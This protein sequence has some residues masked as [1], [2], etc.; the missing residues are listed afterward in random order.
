LQAYKRSCEFAREKTTETKNEM[1]ENFPTYAIFKKMLS[2]STPDLQTY[3][4]GGSMQQFK[5]GT[6]AQA[7]LLFVLLF[8]CC[9]LRTR[10]LLSGH[11]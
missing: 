6:R 2:S 3:K 7:L 11:I 10:L 9:D 1:S 4:I 5:V 8:S